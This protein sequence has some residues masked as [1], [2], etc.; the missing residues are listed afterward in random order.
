MEEY[1]S[2]CCFFRQTPYGHWAAVWHSGLGHQLHTHIGT[3]D[4][5]VFWINY[6]INAHLDTF[7]RGLAFKSSKG[8]CGMPSAL[9]QSSPEALD[10]LETV[11]GVVLLIKM[12][13][14]WT[15]HHLQPPSNNDGN[16]YSSQSCG[17]QGTRPYVHCII[18]SFGQ[19]WTIAFRI[20]ISHLRELRPR[21]RWL[22]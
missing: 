18:Y 19:F 20:P 21:D 15:V 3:Y 16:R 13:Y 11:N 8:H 7:S 10:Y 1:C 6:G 2:F 4:I 12:P 17:A 14:I 5:T 9:S 22:F